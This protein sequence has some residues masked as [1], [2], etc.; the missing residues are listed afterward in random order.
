VAQVDPDDDSLRRYVVFHYRY[1]PERRERRNVLEA[2]FD[3][4]AEFREY[5]D[6]SRA[7]LD[8]DAEHGSVDQREHFHGTVWEPGYREQTRKNRIVRRLMFKLPPA[9]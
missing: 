3:N 7:R 8:S 5:I 9:D 1:D 6:R 4:E 2:A